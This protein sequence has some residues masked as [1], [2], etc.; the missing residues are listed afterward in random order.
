MDA[1][2]DVFEMCRVEGTVFSR[3]WCAAPWGVSSAQSAHGIFH[4]VLRGGCWV[5]PEGEA[6]QRLEPGDVVFLPHG[7][8]HVMCDAPGT[9]TRPILEVSEPGIDGGAG[10]L[11]IEG[12]GER[13][14]LLCGRVSFDREHPLLTALPEVL[15]SRAVPG[16]ERS[17]ERT[18]TLLGEELSASEAGSQVTVSRLTEV[19][20]VQ[21]LRDWLF[22][23]Q[24]VSGWLRGLTDARVARA[25]GNIHRRPQVSWSVEE[26]ARVAGMSR[27]GFA[28]TFH[29]L[30]G[31]TP[32]K[33]LARWRMHLTARALSQ[34]SES[35]AS[36]A[37][38]VGY[39]SEFSLSRA[40]KAAMGESPSHYR[41]RVQ[42][43]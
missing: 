22:Q 6:A 35:L 20:L 9:P 3:A 25:L 7:H 29:T 34:G 15:I 40:F 19:L 26:L 32:A 23:G 21:A 1:L 14:E 17:R 36:I 18:L 24:G 16:R 42:G 11:V 31:E 39:A 13:T 28:A 38:Q 43:A 27:S 4:G 10:R 37:A 5:V 33:Y 30:V 8:G 2:A 12:D 41:T